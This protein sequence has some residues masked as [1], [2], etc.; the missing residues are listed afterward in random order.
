MAEEF[1]F[2]ELSGVEFKRLI[3]GKT[4]CKLLNDKFCHHNFQYKL[5]LNIDKNPFNPTGECCIGGLYFI[6]IENI[7]EFMDYGNNLASIEIPDNARVYCERGKYKADMFIINSIESPEEYLDYLPREVIHKIMVKC[8]AK[9][10]M[11]DM[12]LAK[13]IV[14]YNQKLC[15]MAVGIYG[16]VIRYV[17][18]QTPEM[19]L[20]AVEQNSDAIRFIREPTPEMYMVAVKKWGITLRDIKE[21]TPEICIVAVQQY[22]F[23]L[24]HVGKQTPEICMAAIMKNSWA[25]YFVREQTLELCLEAVKKDHN[26]ICYVNEEF[27]EICIKHILASRNCS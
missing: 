18:K 13:R 9:F 2:K 11:F 20:A 21:P 19:C 22:P 25:L 27:R 8:Q 3:K 1:L 5:G 16:N 17:E 4:F 26:A 6:D 10:F 24:Q 7:V 23:A 12:E 14:N 15:E